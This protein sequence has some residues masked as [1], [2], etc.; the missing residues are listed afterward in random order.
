MSIAIL[1]NVS[2]MLYSRQSRYYGLCLLLSTLS[3]LIYVNWLGGLRPLVALAMILVGL[4]ATNPI[5]YLGCAACLLADYLIWKCRRWKLGWRGWLMLVLPQVVLGGLIVYVWNPIGKSIHNYQ[6]AD[7][8]GEHLRLLWWNLRDLNTCE[9]GVGILMA[10]APLLY[11]LKRDEWLLRGPLA[12]FVYCLVV[13]F[14]SPQPAPAHLKNHAELRYLAPLIP[15]CIFV[16]ARVVLTVTQR[17]KFLAIPL[18]LLA[19]GTNILTGGPYAGGSQYMYGRN[20]PPKTFGS[21]FVRFVGELIDPP[22]SAFRAAS[23]WVNENVKYGQSVWIPSGA[24]YPLMYHAPKA[25]YAWQ[26]KWPPEE[27]FKGLAEIHFEGRVKPDY[28]IAFGPNV[29]KAVPYVQPRRDGSQAEYRFVHHIPLYYYDLSRPELFWH[30]F[31]K[32]T[33][34]NP[35]GEGVF[36]FERVFPPTGSGQAGSAR[37]PTD[38]GSQL[39]ANAHPGH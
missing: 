7:W 3:C 5:A 24:R 18:A 4:L 25:L 37:S 11:F 17:A 27:Q 8:L 26:L 29:R 15:L 2:L 9:F 16:G 10:A 30:A 33:D 28:I 22:P 1:G 31:K 38:A 13:A 36:I 23:D 21:T 20:L 14:L 6:P 19:F 34:F 35:R 39:I 32:V 12:I